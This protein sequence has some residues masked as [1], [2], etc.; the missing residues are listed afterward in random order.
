MANK[1]S[2]ENNTKD[3]EEESTQ[4]GVEIFYTFWQYALN[5][6]DSEGKRLP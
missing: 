3:S 5:D 4:N 1:I 2:A 6:D